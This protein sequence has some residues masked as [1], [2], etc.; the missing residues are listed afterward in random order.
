[1]IV[2]VGFM[3]AGKTTVGRLLA[4]QLGLPFTDAD[5]IIERQAGRP[6]PEIFATQGEAAFRALEHQVTAGLLAG[7]EAV[8]ALGGGAAQHPATQRALDRHHVV[9]LEVGYAEAM[10]RIGPDAGRPM[11]RR[12]DLQK[13]FRQ[14]L[15]GYQAVATV[16]VRTGGRPPAEVCAEILA[17]LPQASDARP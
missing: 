3:G 7:P 15:A 10:G 14:R 9:Y 11:L 13:V 8:L 4:D 5:L 6:I 12:P 2:L 16:V 17:G 1:M